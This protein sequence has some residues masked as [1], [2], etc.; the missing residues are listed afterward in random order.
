[1]NIFCFV[2]YLYINDKHII[3]IAPHFYKSL[4]YLKNNY[5]K[6]KNSLQ[7]GVKLLYPIILGDYNLT[8][9]IFNN[10]CNNNFDNYS[11]YHFT[12]YFTEFNS[13]LIIETLLILE[14]KLKVLFVNYYLSEI[15]PVMPYITKDQDSIFITLS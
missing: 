6:E 8:K 10:L 11:D 4:K 15:N 3:Y 12:L 13:E 9:A 14:N 2:R 7:Q 5:Y 1:M